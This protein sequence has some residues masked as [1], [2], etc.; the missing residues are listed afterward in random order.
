MDDLGVPNVV[1]RILAKGI[2]EESVRRRCDDRS[3]RTMREMGRCYMAG[4][5]DRG[6]NHEPKTQAAS[7]EERKVKV[8]D[9]APR[10]SRR[11]AGLQTHCLL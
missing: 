6:R 7:I 5:E 9:S 1:A 10:E 4:S 3:R 2:Q 11:N 8:M